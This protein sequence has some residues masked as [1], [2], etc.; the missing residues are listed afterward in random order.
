MMNQRL[1]SDDMVDAVTHYDMLIEENN[2][3]FRDPPHLKEHMNLWDGDVF[4]GLLKLDKTKDVLE[5]GVG[6]GRLAVKVAPKC[7]CLTGIDFSPKTIARARENLRNCTNMVLICDDFLQHDFAKSFDI[8]YSSLT[9]MHFEDKRGVVVKVASL[10]NDGGVFC[11]SIDKNQS[12]CIDMGSRRVRIFPDTP[13]AIIS[14]LDQSGMKV[15][16]VHE[17]ENAYIVCC[18]K[19]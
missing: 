13:E 10:L 17:V 7:L 4:L 8:V 16:R 5:I 2:D 3:P 9:M 12:T 15:E 14:L 11:L 1:G 18:C 6:T 19:G